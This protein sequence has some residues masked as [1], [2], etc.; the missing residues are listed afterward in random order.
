MSQT[1]PNNEARR[2]TDFLVIGTGIAGLTFALRAAEARKSPGA[3][4]AILW[5]RLSEG[6]RVLE[7]L[8]EAIAEE[9]LEGDGI[10]FLGS[11]STLKLIKERLGIDG[12]LLGVDVV[13]VKDGRARLLV[14]DATERDL[15]R[16]VDRNPR[17]VVTVVGGLNFL[18][19][20]GNQQISERV[21]C[22]IGKENI[23]IVATPLKLRN[24][25]KLRMDLENCENLRGY[26][27]VLMG[28][29]KYRVIKME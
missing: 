7:A 8:A 3:E 18:F 11:G 24:L 6:R 1:P 25:K 22:R 27:R 19:G 14:K 9:I 26:Y 10:Y 29:G 15:L 28:Y 21:L 12:T 4:A 23:I 20:R 16:F 2:S 5:E 13:E 17:I